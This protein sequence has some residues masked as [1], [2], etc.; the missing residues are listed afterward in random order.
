MGQLRAARRIGG[1]VG[2]GL[3][4]RHQQILLVGLPE[5]VRQMPSLGWVALSVAAHHQHF[6]AEPQH[7]IRQAVVAA[8]EFVRQELQ[9]EGAETDTLKRLACAHE[10]VGAH[11]VVR[12]GREVAPRS[13]DPRQTER[14]VH[15]SPRQRAP[16]CGS[17]KTRAIR[18]ARVARG[19][20]R[21]RSS[22]AL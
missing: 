9:A 6:Q 10:S 16:G 13:P 8:L 19:K 15:G 5:R 20:A 14:H 2:L 17:R 12:K 7:L 18:V 11:M 21:I 4:V 22:C 3:I 1:E